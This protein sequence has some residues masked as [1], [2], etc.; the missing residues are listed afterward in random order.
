MIVAAFLA[1]T[2]AAAPPYPVQEV[3]AAFGDVCLDPKSDWANYTALTPTQKAEAWK[4]L[5]LKKGWTE[6][7]APPEAAA[8]FQENSAART[9]YSARALDYELFLPLMQLGGERITVQALFNRQVAGRNVFISIFGAETSNPTIAECRLHD[10]LGDGINKR[11]VAKADIERWLGRT[12][13]RSAAPYRGTQYSWPAKPFGRAIQVH[14][15]FAGKPFATYGAKYDPYAL[16]GMTL[17]RSDYS[18]DIII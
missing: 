6:V 5:A 7:A 8:T 12:V 1:A 3:L 14:F 11:P 18:N 16:Y 10:P 4:E 15:G 13:K 9:Y 2:T 17:V